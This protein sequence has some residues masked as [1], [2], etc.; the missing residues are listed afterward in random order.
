MSCPTPLP[1]SRG[2]DRHHVSVGA[3]LC[4]LPRPEAGQRSRR[5]AAASRRRW[6]GSAP[7]LLRSRSAQ[8]PLTAHGKGPEPLNFSRWSPPLPPSLSFSLLL[9]CAAWGLAGLAKA[10]LAGGSLWGQL[11]ALG[12]EEDAARAAGWFGFTAWAFCEP[13]LLK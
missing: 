10:C 1:F 8:P 12:G 6:T 9:S 13:E 11:L 5:R 4:A 3:S 7:P 2:K